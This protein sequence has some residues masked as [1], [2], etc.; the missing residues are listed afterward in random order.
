MGMAASQAR[1]L[2][3]TSRKHT[4][5]LQL[6]QLANDK[7]SLS[8]DMQRVS[9]EYQNA[10][11]QKTFKWSN[12]SGVSY[13]DLSY[14]NLMRPS[15]MNQNRPYVLTDS[16]GKVIIDTAY[17][18]YA[19]KISPNGAPGGDWESVR[20]EIIASL[21]GID[22]NDLEKQLEYKKQVKQC[23]NELNGILDGKPSR[24]TKTEEIEDFLDYAKPTYSDKKIDELY[25]NDGTIDLGSNAVETLRNFISGVSNTLSQYLD[26]E[27]AEKLTD[28][29]NGF[30]NQYTS[31]LQNNAYDNA[32]EE[33]AIYRKDGQYKLNVKATLDTILSPL[34]SCTDK[35]GDKLITWNDINNENYNTREQE[36]T[37]WENSKKKAEEKYQTALDSSN[38]LFDSDQERLIDFYDAIFSTIAEKGWTHNVEVNDENYLNQMLQNNIYTITTVERD[39]K[40]NGTNNELTWDNEYETD[41]ASNFNNLF[42]VND[43]EAREEAQIEYENKKRVIE[44]KETRI[45]TRMRTLET[46]Q[47]SI[48]QMLEGLNKVKDENID[49]TMDITG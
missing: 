43:N 46:E 18:K 19:E 42:M 33:C 7:V 28:S 30:L 21:T 11:T 34:G 47:S 9:R 3:L 41:I 32:N 5:G 36:I 4:I 14:S 38:Q 22:P 45:D 29:C 17:R 1:L 15:A 49:R 40:Y 35:S 12:N 31:Y 37:A 27:T 6:T 26:E 44:A 13:I 23:E 24:L 20:A 2:Q 8:R 16:S 39:A 48:N 10:L 25:S